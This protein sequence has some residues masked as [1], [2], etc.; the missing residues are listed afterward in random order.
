MLK[1]IASLLSNVQ[2]FDGMSR[3]EMTVKEIAKVYNPAFKEG[4]VV[5]VAVGSSYYVC[6]E[7]LDLLALAE[8]I[9]NN[10]FLYVATMPKETLEKLK[11]KLG[12]NNVLPVE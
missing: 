8:S 12:K 4:N 9:G 7:L 10:A 6:R 3:Q 11:P 5:L 2:V 1:M